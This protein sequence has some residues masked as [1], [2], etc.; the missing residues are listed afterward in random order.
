[1]GFNILIVDDSATTRA[2]IKRAV[3]LSGAAEGGKV[4]EAENGRH[5]LAVLTVTHVDLVLADLHMPEMTGVEM[6]Q[7]MLADAKLRHVPVVVVSAEPST[8]KLE[9]LKSQGV[10]N[11]V[12]KPFTPEAIRNVINQTLG[13][14]RAA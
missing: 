6:T 11:Y 9:Q 7:R 12:R 2:M 14:N 3:Q 10:R 1:M 4:L 5:G 8:E 13:V